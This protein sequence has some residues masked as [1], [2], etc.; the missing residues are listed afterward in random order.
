MLGNISA[1]FGVTRYRLGES[2][3]NFIDRADKMLYKAKHGGR[4]RV[5][6]DVLVS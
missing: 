6:V 3:E 1:S 4:N 2:V 5:E